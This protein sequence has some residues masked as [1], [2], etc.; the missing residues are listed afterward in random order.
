MSSSVS[1]AEP[2]VGQILSK[3]GKLFKSGRL[4][5]VK[6]LTRLLD[7]S[8]RIKRSIL[9]C[10]HFCLAVR[11]SCFVLVLQY[12]RKVNCLVP[13]R[14]DIYLQLNKAVFRQTTR[15]LSI[16]FKEV[17]IKKCLVQFAGTA[18]LT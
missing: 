10:R 13:S 18:S 12:C 2:K 1:R 11:R 3:A 6:V 9:P 16:T 7:I 14:F 8:S 4:E 15:Y 17:S 5:V